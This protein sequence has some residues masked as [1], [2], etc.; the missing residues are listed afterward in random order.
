M[1]NDSI[2]TS[3]IGLAAYLLT[4][5]FEVDYLDRNNPQ[6]V[7]FVFSESKDVQQAIDAYFAG[8][9]LVE[10]KQY[11]FQLKSLKSRLLSGL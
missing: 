6:R 4:I 1:K 3:D 2:N 7:E 8:N 10:P 5:G 11:Y 9:A